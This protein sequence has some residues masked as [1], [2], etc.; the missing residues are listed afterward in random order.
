MIEHALRVLHLHCVD[1]TR[2]NLR[3][4]L[5]LSID[6]SLADDSFETVLGGICTLNTIGV[7]GHLSVLN[8]L[9]HHHHFIVR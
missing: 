8:R 3:N 9:V 7:W 4:V 1:R 2:A 6:V 5:E